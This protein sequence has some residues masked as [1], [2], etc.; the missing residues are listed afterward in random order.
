MFQDLKKR[1]LK[2]C[3]TAQSLKCLPLPVYGYIYLMIHKIYKTPAA[4]DKFDKTINSG[5]YEIRLLVA[6]AMRYVDSHVNISDDKRSEIKLIISELLI[7]A[8][9]HGN[10]NNIHK[11]IRLNMGITKDEKLLIQVEDEGMGLKR[12]ILRQKKTMAEDQRLSL[13]EGGRGL[14]LIRKLSGNLYTRRE[15][16][17]ICTKISISSKETTP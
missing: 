13:D 10:K 8:L 4:G 17:R 6:D 7:N 1:Y 16:K 3:G 12:K 14:M 5:M 9:Y 11:K 2:K 15:G